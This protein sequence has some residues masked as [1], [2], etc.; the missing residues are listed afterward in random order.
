[1]LISM[2]IIIL[3]KPYSALK[4]KRVV[5]VSAPVITVKARGTMEATSRA[6][7]LKSEIP[8]II[9]KA[10]KKI[11]N[12]PATANEC[13]SIP[14]RP[15]IFLPK[16]N[17]NHNQSGHKRCF[18]RLYMACFFSQTDDNG[19]ALHYDNDSKKY[20]TGGQNSFKIHFINLSKGSS[21][22]F[23]F[24]HFMLNLQCT[25]MITNFKM[26]CFK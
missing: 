15:N 12:D 11:T 1:M 17:G 21:L 22:L 20:R 7:S 16:K 5:M 19:S 25:V 26:Q 8:K 10:K 23:Y 13:K 2:A 9:F 18:F 14:I 4:V 6:S 24:F 3:T